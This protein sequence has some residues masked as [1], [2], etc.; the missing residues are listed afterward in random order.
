MDAWDLY[1]WEG[2]PSEGCSGRAM[3]VEILLI[4]LDEIGELLQCSRRVLEE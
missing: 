1:H 4:G 3:G 2:E